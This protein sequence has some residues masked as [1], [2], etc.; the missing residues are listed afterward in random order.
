[1]IWIYDSLAN[2]LISVDLACPMIFPVVFCEDT[3]KSSRAFCSW[4][5]IQVFSRQM[6]TQQLV[7]PL[8]CRNNIRTQA[9]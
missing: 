5:V 2:F 1:M 6:T 3:K 9:S 8:H 7:V 4:N